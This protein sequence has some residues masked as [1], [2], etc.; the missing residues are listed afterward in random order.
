MNFMI[1]SKIRRQYF[2]F[3]YD[4]KVIEAKYD[5][6]FETDNGEEFNSPEYEAYNA[7]AFEN[8][9]TLGLKNGNRFLLTKKRRA[10]TRLFFWSYW[11]DSNRRPADY[12][13]AAL[14]TEPQ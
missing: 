11:P 6:M 14:P 2:Q 1:K 7:I 5:T 10:Q 8:L 13:S 4:D 3:V 9:T 12:E